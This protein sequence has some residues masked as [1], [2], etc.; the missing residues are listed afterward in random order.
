M[1]FALM[2][3]IINGYVIGPFFLPPRL[4]A[5]LFLNFLTNHLFDLFDEVPIATRMNS[6]FQMDGAPKHFGRQVH[7]PLFNGRTLSK[8][9]IQHDPVETGATLQKLQ[10]DIV[11]QRHVEFSNFDKSATSRKTSNGGK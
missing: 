7:Y 2:Y 8:Q 10:I 3:G 9:L 11:I 1:G 6:W 4:N 5:N